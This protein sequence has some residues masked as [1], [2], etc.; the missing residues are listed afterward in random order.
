[1]IIRVN[2]AILHVCCVMSG[3]MFMSNAEL[4]LTEPG[5]LEY[6]RALIPKAMTNPAKVKG[7]FRSNS[8]CAG[9]IQR[10]KA[11]ATKFAEMSK[12]IAERIY[13]GIEYS[14][15]QHNTDVLIAE[16]TTNGKADRYIAV[17][18]LDNKDG[19]RHALTLS[20]DGES[21]NT[22]IEYCTSDIL[23]KSTQTVNEFAIINLSSLEIGYAGKM[24]KVDGERVDLM[25]DVVLE[26]EPVSMSSKQADTEIK[27]LIRSVS[28]D[29][30]ESTVKLKETLTDI[31][32][33]QVNEPDK[34][35]DLETVSSNIFKTYSEKQQFLDMAKE[36]GLITSDGDKLPLDA[37]TI[38]KLNEKV[39][40]V[41]DN[42]YEIKF[43]HQLRDR[44][45]FVHEDDG[46]MS[47]KLK[48]VNEVTLK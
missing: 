32:S 38:K 39:K 2:K 36:R 25:R 12:E 11:N 20:K 5:I 29:A 21:V 46:S 3:E 18:K 14:D 33:E 8:G 27:K 42:G 15:K 13:N 34:T 30:F 10:Y 47:I 7:Q 45:E 26:C 48:D 43:P 31:V 37:Y 17:L 6:V 23:P 35:Y 40:V 22:S 4:D 19:F 41:T 16:I 44:I 1:M 9:I 28:N 24:Y